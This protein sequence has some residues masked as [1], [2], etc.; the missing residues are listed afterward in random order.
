VQKTKKA[1]LPI[2][3]QEAHGNHLPLNTDNII[4]FEL[5]RKASQLTGAILLPLLPYGHIRG[6]RNFPGSVSLRENLLKEVIL[7]IANSIY[8][9]GIDRLYVINGHIPNSH[10]IDAASEEIA[11]KVKIFNLTYPNSSEIYKKFCDSNQWHPGIFHAEEI[12]T[13]LILYLK[14]KL[15]KIDKAITNYPN[16][17]LDFGFRYIPWE[18]FNIHGIIGDP[19]KASARK[20]KLIFK[21]LLDYIVDFINKT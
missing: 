14:P 1:I 6:L 10:A 8:K 18:E 19:T 2:G 20:G 11:P 15:V 7:D 12:E 13:S 9:D 21:F 5:A 4:A 16:K 17:P 3:A